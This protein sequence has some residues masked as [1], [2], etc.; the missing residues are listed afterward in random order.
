MSPHH[1]GLQDHALKMGEGFNAL[2]NVTEVALKTI[3]G[4]PVYLPEVP[5]LDL[6]NRHQT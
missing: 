3:I 5:T 1:R 2:F 4:S 6:N